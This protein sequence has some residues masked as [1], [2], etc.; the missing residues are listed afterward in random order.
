[1]GGANLPLFLGGIVDFLCPKNN[2]TFSFGNLNQK[3]G[4]YGSVNEPPTGVTDAIYIHFRAS[5]STY[6]YRVVIC[7]DAGTSDNRGMYYRTYRSS[8]SS[9]Y[10]VT[11]NVLG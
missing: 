11:S 1:M 9:W 2:E 7:F 5:S 4:V 10:Q 8:W 6:Y 3:S